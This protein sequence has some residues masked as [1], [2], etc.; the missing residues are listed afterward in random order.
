L[1]LYSAL[2]C[3]VQMLSRPLSAHHGSASYRTGNVVVLKQATV[4]K[5]L[6]ANPHTVLLFDVKD[7]KGNVSHWA[8]EAGSPS[9]VRRLGWSKNS[10]Q[11]GDVITIHLYP[12][13]FES[14]VGRVEKIVLVDGRTLKNS[15]RGDLGV[16]SRY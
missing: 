2:L 15:P 3:G 14:N 1:L 11:P 8:G 4:T 10:L 9:A 6:W 5:F 12:S 13:K 7:D 16:E